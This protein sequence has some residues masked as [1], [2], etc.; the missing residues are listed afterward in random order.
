MK[1][2]VI[3]QDADLEYDPSEIPKL[4]AFAESALPRK[5]A[6]YGRR[7]CCWGMP[8]RWLFATGVLGID[9]LLLIAYRRWVRDHASCYKL[10][11]RS[12]LQ[13][14]DLN[15]TGFEGCIEITAKLMP[16]QIPI[17]QVPISYTPRKTTEGKKL[18]IGYGLTAL[19]SIWFYRSWKPD[20]LAGSER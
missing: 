6:V 18:T 17:L 8:S 13:S 7:P 9:C 12:I 11:P 1:L 19:R 5:V 10:V 3:V 20:R 2:S 14:F 16:S 15:A 4:L